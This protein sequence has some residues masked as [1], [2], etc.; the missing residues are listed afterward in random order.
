M[1]MR[2]AC[3][4]SVLVSVAL[5]QAQDK[6]K[7]VRIPVD[8]LLRT[9][10]A[11]ELPRLTPVDGS[12]PMLALGPA[13]PGR[14]DTRLLDFVAASLNTESGKCSKVRFEKT[15]IQASCEGLEATRI[16]DVV[17]DGIECLVPEIT[18]T[19]SVH[20]EAPSP[21]PVV[22]APGKDSS[23]PRKTLHSRSLVCASAQTTTIQLGKL[24]LRL[25]PHLLMGDKIRIALLCE[26]ESEHQNRGG[27][28]RWTAGTASAAVVSGSRMVLTLPGRV[29]AVQAVHK[30]R[31]VGTRSRIGISW[32]LLTTTALRMTPSL[33]KTGS[34]LQYK[35]LPPP[36]NS[37]LLL[38]YVR[39]H[40]PLGGVLAC[41]MGS[42]LLLVSPKPELLSEARRATHEDFAELMRAW[43]ETAAVDCT[44]TQKA[45]AAITRLPTLAGRACVLLHTDATGSER[46][47]ALVAVN[48]HPD[49]GKLED[50]PAHL[51]SHR[52]G[53]LTGFA[54]SL[55]GD[56]TPSSKEIPIELDSVA[57]PGPTHLVQGK[58]IRLKISRQ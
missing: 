7:V 57:N 45:H 22:L 20:S 31:P 2:H 49:L 50:L 43:T 37:D 56:A 55:C 33:G 1:F 15:A 44:I 8:H 38:A 17:L 39:E 32:S 16:R 27:M 42:R 29:V 13:N 30:P 10:K 34:L 36:S 35:R 23:L 52:H 51:R 18:L 6:D 12:P 40:V 3:A 4:V 11:A 54:V 46:Q 24:R 41:A 14:P 48:W 47:G 25:Q 9:E 58:D 21:S 26:F 19:V 53:Q 5:A 28:C